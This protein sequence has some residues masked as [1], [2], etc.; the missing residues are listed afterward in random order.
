M[1]EI[2]KKADINAVKFP[3]VKD[4]NTETISGKYHIAGN[5]D[6]SIMYENYKSQINSC[7]HNSYENNEEAYYKIYR[8]LF[9]E[10]RYKNKIIDWHNE[11]KETMSYAIIKA[12]VTDVKKILD[13][14]DEYIDQVEE[15]RI[16]E[17]WLI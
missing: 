15:G 10:L 14:Y 17:K 7:I 3:V 8:K 1:D 2:N 13:D 12:I 5:V 11:D 9:R 4:N 6:R 16:V